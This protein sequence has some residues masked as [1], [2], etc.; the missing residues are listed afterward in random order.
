MV[1]QGTQSK[2]GSAVGSSEYSWLCQILPVSSY[3]SQGLF[4]TKRKLGFSGIL[5]LPQ[6]RTFSERR[7]CLSLLPH[8]GKL[9][10][11]HFTSHTTLRHAPTSFAQQSL[12]AFP[13]SGSMLCEGHRDERTKFLLF[14]KFTIKFSAQ[15]PGFPW[16][17]IIRPQNLLSWRVK[18]GKCQERG[19]DVQG[20]KD[21]CQL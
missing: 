2:L 7:T 5:P 6:K 14:M 18:R 8:T 1:S 10:H 16:F 20:S 9:K 15:G 12:C 19:E 3:F 11:H 21:Y 13:L 17:R 4:E